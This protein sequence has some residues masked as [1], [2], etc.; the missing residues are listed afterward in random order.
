MK[1]LKLHSEQNFGIT[2]ISNVFLDEFAF[3]QDSHKI[4]AALFPV[5]SA[6]HKLRITSTPNGKENKFYELMTDPALDGLW[7][8]HRIDIHEA[9]RQGL[10]RDINLLRRGLNDD[11]AWAQEYEIQWLDEASAW[12]PFDL[13]VSAEDELAGLPSAYQRGPCYVG[14]DIAARNDLFV[15]WVLESVGDILWTREMIVRKRISFAE[16]DTLLD[17]VFRRYRVVKCYMDQSGM[18][19]PQLEG[20][21][22]RHGSRVEGILFSQASKVA[23]ATVGKQAFEDRKIRIP[24][25]DTAL[26]S[27]L[28]QLKKEVGPTGIPRFIAEHTSNGHADRAWAC[29]LA[30]YAASGNLGEVSVSSRRRRESAALLKGYGY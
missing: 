1:T 29:F 14:V 23:M 19:E 27:D 6:G 30:C 5:I 20:A 21:R 25:D 13:I 17:E 26:R 3:H 24:T 10:P 8:R 18:G 16:Q 7:S 2:T 15:I 12:L 9:V 22:R 11:D 28:H 4:W